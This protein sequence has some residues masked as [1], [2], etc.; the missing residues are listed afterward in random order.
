MNVV[1]QWVIVTVVV[2]AAIIIPLYKRLKHGK[3]PPKGCS[4]CND[5][6]IAN[7]CNK[8]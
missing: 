1:A 4:G 6:P 3:R 2:L 7:D 5:C 8:K